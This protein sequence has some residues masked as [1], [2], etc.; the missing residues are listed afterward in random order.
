MGL[1]TSLSPRC[2]QTPFLSPPPQPFLCACICA[3]VSWPRSLALFHTPPCLFSLKRE[4][5]RRAGGGGGGHHLGPL[6]LLCP[7]NHS[8]LSVLGFSEKQG[9]PGASQRRLVPVAPAL[10]QPPPAPVGL[11][12]S[13]PRL[14]LPPHLRNPTALPAPGPSAGAELHLNPES[15]KLERRG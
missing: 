2:P 11:C 3:A 4:A 8:G 14:R 9:P 13:M 1:Q 10:L 6:P 7:S 12:G 15:E 5:G